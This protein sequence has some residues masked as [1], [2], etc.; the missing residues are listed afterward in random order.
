MADERL[1]RLVAT[2]VNEV[3]DFFLLIDDHARIE[4]A[5]D[6]SY[7]VLGYDRGSTIGRSIAEFLHPDDLERAATVMAHID[8]GNLDVPVTPAFYRL[9]RA[10]GAW[11]R[12]E[13]NGIRASDV[14]TAPTFA[15]VAGDLVAL[16]AGRVVVAHNLGFDTRFLRYE[17]DRLGVT[18]P[19]DVES[20][21]CT[22]AMP[23]QAVVRLAG[24]V[25]GIAPRGERNGP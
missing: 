18:V 13:F 9:R 11:L 19:L 22:M 2:A 6:Y 20:G 3:N 23:S 8:A 4:W 1:L 17:Y 7:E 10:D 16:L 15:D 5:N 24:A 14:R 12:I 21:L 25:L